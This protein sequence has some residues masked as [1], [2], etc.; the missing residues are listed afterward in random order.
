MFQIDVDGNCCA[1]VFCFSFLVC[2]LVFVLVYPLKMSC[3]SCYVCF[4]KHLGSGL[5][6]YDIVVS[7]M[8][9]D[10]SEEPALSS[11]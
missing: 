11:R 7:Y 10:I 9:T 3:S 8:V 5:M 2:G 6:G 1:S 4:Y